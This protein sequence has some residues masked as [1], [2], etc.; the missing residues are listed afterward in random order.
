MRQSDSGRVLAMEANLLL[1]VGVVVFA[2]LPA[3]TGRSVG[4]RGGERQQG[5]EEHQ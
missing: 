1:R 5:A 3:G 4:S 2:S